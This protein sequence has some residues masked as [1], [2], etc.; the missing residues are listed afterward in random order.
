MYKIPY[1]LLIILPYILDYH[2]LAF[3]FLVATA[4]SVTCTANRTVVDSPP[5]KR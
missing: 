5:F 1:P 3:P 2:N 4:A